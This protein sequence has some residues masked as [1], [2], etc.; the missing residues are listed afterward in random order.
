M[1]TGSSGRGRRGSGGPADDWTDGPA[2]DP[3]RRWRPPLWLQVHAVVVSYWPVLLAVGVVSLPAAVDAGRWWAGL[4]GYLV[5]LWA[6]L[7]APRRVWTRLAGVLGGP[8][9]PVALLVGFNLL[10][11][12]LAR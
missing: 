5:A 6:L 8:F 1:L 9:R 11:R 12:A 3:A 4:F 2:D 10:M 7:A